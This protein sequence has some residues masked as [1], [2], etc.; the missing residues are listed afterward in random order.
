M[1]K[2]KLPQI[3]TTYK[4]HAVMHI[5]HRNG[6]ATEVIASPEDVPWLSVM[7][8]MRLGDGRAAT[9]WF[10]T[11]WALMHRLIVGVLGSEVVDHINR[12]FLDNRRENLRICTQRQNTMNQGVGRGS[13][14]PFKGVSFDH[15]GR[16]KPYR[17]KIAFNG[18]LSN[19]GSYATPEEA[20][21]AYDKRAMLVH[22]DFA[23][24]NKSLG[25]LK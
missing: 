12:D 22:G 17:A 11:D 18:K 3:W 4:D 21:I 16:K 14:V 15:D 8:W 9:T 24:T 19:I 6:N 10:T 7:R 2:R 23:L 1:A 5:T 20:A 25:L 13:D